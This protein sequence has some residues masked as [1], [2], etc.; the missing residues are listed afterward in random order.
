MAITSPRTRNLKLY[1]SSGLTAEAR[2]N[3]ELIDK[4]GET[5]SSDNTNSL[6]IRQKQ[7]I[8]LLP[9][10]PSVG[11]TAGQGSLFFGSATSPILNLK[12][13]TTNFEVTGSF[14]LQD[15]SGTQKLTLKYDSSASAPISDSQNRNLTIDVQAGDRKLILGGDLKTTNS[16]DIT[17]PTIP[18][19]VLIPYSGTLVLSS[20]V[21]TLSQK[22]I[23]ALTNSITDLTQAAFAPS[24]NLPLSLISGGVVSTTEFSYITGV[25]SSIQA[26]L[27]GK[28]PVGPYITALTGAITASGPGS[29]VTVLS[30]NSV[31]S[32][33]IQP[34]SIL[35]SNLFGGIS[36]SKIA[37]GSAL[38]VVMNAADGSMTSAAS[39]PANR[40]GTGVD[41]SLVTFPTSGIILTNTNNAT[42]S[43]KVMD[44]SF[45]FFSNI[46][47]GSLNLTNG[48]T[49]FD[50]SP[51][52][53]ITYSKLNLS[54]GIVNND[55]SPSA[56]ISGLKVSP[57]FG[58]QLVKS[59]GGFEF[60]RAGQKTTL[61]AALP[62]AGQVA[63]LTFALPPDLG[64]S[65]YFL[66]TSGAGQLVWANPGFGGTVTSIGLTAP[67]EFTV[68]NS[69]ITTAG[70]LSLNWAPVLPKA[71]L[72]G[73]AVLGPASVP[74]FRILQSTDLPNHSHNHLD[75]YDFDESVQ[76]VVGAMVQASSSVSWAY[77]DTLNTLSAAVSLAPFTT[78]QLAEGSNLY[79]TIERAQDAVFPAVATSPDLSLIYNDAG[80]SAT[81]I[82]NSGLITAK[83]VVIPA[84][85][86]TILLSD[87]SNSGTLSQV[88]LSDVG[89]LLGISGTSAGVAANWV[90]LNG[91]SK[92]I[93]HGLGTRD[94][95]IQ[96]YDN[97]T[98][99]E[100]H[101]DSVVRLDTMTV[102]LQASEAPSTSWRV[103]I[104][105]L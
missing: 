79:F 41:G 18:G 48:I 49:N 61:V 103:L 64:T 21:Q 37:A 81:V 19:P 78:A 94:V 75:M 52:A 20:G 99:E 29:A 54:S 11:G 65:G 17:G 77:N 105:P 2:I 76:D 100:V 66:S 6:F 42:V 9:G 1:L 14:T 34:A 25:T 91:T 44:G 67:V 5:F 74:T 22:S 102:V 88:S 95:L 73:S 32:S 104:K 8:H 16:L 36:R 10:D 87:T 97:V 96:I 98:F 31:S 7:D 27:N 56:A 83:P 28:Q 43:N 35:D 12:I 58:S 69:P 50:V 55:I 24:T 15:L 39:L 70:N 84:L 51:A 90:L 68:T 45:N 89:T 101:V 23:S 72:M 93:V 3:L 33:N 47:Y 62:A 86:D 4:L 82:A 30:P 38:H 80:N 46:S 71:V 85:N 60:S 63:D 92:T 53:A 57:S 13:F 26:Q 59:S 40:G